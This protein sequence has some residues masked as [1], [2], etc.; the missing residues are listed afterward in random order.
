MRT[1]KVRTQPILKSN[2]ALNS[3]GKVEHTFILNKDGSIKE[4]PIDQFAGR[5]FMLN[6]DGWIKNDIQAYEEAQSDSVARKILQRISIVNSPNQED[7]LSLEDRLNEIIPSNYSSPA[8][9]VR[10]SRRLGEL[11]FAR[12]QASKQKVEEPVKPDTIK[13]EDSKDE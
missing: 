4:L 2:Q 12:E 3:E 7:G 9:F 13:F 1:Y 6:S 5:G 10:I 11:K 8:E